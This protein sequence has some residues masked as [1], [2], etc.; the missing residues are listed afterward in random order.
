MAIVSRKALSSKIVYETILSRCS[1]LG[2]D[3]FVL[4]DSNSSGS[5]LYSSKISFD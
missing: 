3:I 1:K 4:I 2:A 5:E